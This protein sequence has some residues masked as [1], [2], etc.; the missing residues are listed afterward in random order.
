MDC[1]LG[2]SGKIGGFLRQAWQARSDVLWQGRGGSTPPGWL[3]WDMLAGPW[4]GPSLDG[5]A[6]FCLAGV[7]RGDA[8]ALEDNSRLAQA[9]LEAGRRA[10]AGRVFLCSSAA[11]YGRPGPGQWFSE[12]TPPAPVSPYGAAKLQ[13]EENAFDTARRGLGP[14]LT[15]LRIGN[16]LGADALIGGAQP[17]RRV[18]LD[19]VAGEPRGPLRS[20]IGPRALADVLAALASHEVLPEMINIAAP[21][22]VGMAE[23]LQAAGSDWAWGPTNPGVL[24]LAGLGTDRLE[25][26]APGVAGSCDPQ[27]LVADWYGLT[28]GTA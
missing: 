6:I 1:V 25:A 7:I 13:M 17:G 19:P 3:N 22:L 18:I 12:E 23:L 20:Y 21:G 24:P 15:I 8:G 5:G 2:A 9:A 28:T 11:V 10:D 4:P 26:L 27:Q 16:V 14:G